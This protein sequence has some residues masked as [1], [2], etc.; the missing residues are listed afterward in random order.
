MLDPTEELLFFLDVA[1]LAADGSPYDL[2][3]LAGNASNEQYVVG[4]DGHTYYRSEGRLVRW[5]HSS[6][7][8]EVV[9]TLTKQ[10]PGHPRDTG[11]TRDGTTWASYRLGYNS[12]DSGIVWLDWNDQVLGNVEYHQASSRVIGV[13]ADATLHTCGISDD[14]GVACIAAEP[15]A[16]EVLWEVNLGPNGSVVGGALVPNRLY[17]TVDAGSVFALGAFDGAGEP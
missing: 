4:A 6:S 3:D 10:V 17:V 16:E 5:Q 1:Y 14:E 2:G 15:G 13:D 12:P 7:G 9:Q 11:V 8:I